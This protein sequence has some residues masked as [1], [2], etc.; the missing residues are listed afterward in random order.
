[1]LNV[2]IHQT[3][4]SDKWTDENHSKSRQS[5]LRMSLILSKLAF[6]I[7]IE[8]IALKNKMLEACIKK[9]QSVLND[10]K[11]RIKTLMENEGLGNEEEYDNSQLANIAQ[12]IVEANALNDALDFANRE[13]NQLL[14]LKSIHD[15]IHEKAEFGAVVVT[16]IATFFISTSI[17]QFDLDGETFIGLSIYSPLFLKMKGKRKGETFFYNGV[18][19]QIDDIF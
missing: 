4:F 9:Q 8:K 14:Y 19:H 2:K 15:D 7:T 6:M 17:E 1:M 18:T 16:D 3:S 5:L 10:F 11:A 13:M 12:G